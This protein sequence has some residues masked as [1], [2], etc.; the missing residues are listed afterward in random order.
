MPLD[1]DVDGL[2]KSVSSVSDAQAMSKTDIS[3]TRTPIGAA[4]LVTEPNLCAGVSD[5]KKQLMRLI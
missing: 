3:R 1:C 2:D 4:S 5:A